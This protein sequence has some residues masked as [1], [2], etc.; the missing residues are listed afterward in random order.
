MTAADGIDRFGLNAPEPW[1]DLWTE[2]RE[3]VVRRLLLPV[4]RLEARLPA[5]ERGVVPEQ[6]PREEPDARV[7]LRDP[8]R[9]LEVRRLLRPADAEEVVRRLRLVAVLG[10]PE[11]LVAVEAPDPVQG[12]F[13]VAELDRAS[14]A[15]RRRLLARY[16]VV[17]VVGPRVEVRIPAAFA[18][19][20]NAS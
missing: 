11:R 1:S 19:R 6:E 15:A 4:H 20:R 10:D 8:V 14:A 5:A 18:E 16:A 3:R 13:D 12:L 7:R 9:L 17:R 2:A